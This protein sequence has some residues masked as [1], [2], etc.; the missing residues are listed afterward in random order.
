[1]VQE[2]SSMF[3]FLSFLYLSP[4]QFPFFW[5]LNLFHVLASKVLLDV[6]H[7]PETETFSGL[8][9]LCIWVLAAVSKDE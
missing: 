5:F 7:S 6:E 1:M 3:P 2:L 4:E 9:V 8:S